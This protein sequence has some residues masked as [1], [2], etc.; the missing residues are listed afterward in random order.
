MSFR[1]QA[2]LALG[3]EP[4]P[5]TAQPSSPVV[6]PDRAAETEARLN[7]LLDRLATAT[8]LAAVRQA[9]AAA[10]SAKPAPP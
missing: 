3:R 5:A 6:P 9:A 10:R 4:R 1:T 7:A 8:T 2:A